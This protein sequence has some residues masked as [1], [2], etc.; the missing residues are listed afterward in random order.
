[1]NIHAKVCNKNVTKQN[2][3]IYEKFTILWTKWNLFEVCWLNF[4]NQSS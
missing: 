3:V 1:M 2:P 4:K